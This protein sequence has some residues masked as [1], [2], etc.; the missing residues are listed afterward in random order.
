MNAIK[1]TIVMNVNAQKRIIQQTQV[2]HLRI[3]LF[4]EPGMELIPGS[5]ARWDDQQELAVR[6]E[7]NGRASYED[8]PQGKK[9]PLNA[10]DVLLFSAD[11]IHR[12]LYGLDRLAFDILVF[13]EAG[14][15]IDYIDDDCLPPAV[16]M[17]TIKNPRIF[18][19]A[20]AL[21]AQ[22]KRV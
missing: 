10:G 8:L 21:K 17:N 11:M 20:R 5:H 4:N 14:D 12:G 16:M 9:I 6:L 7:L 22:K 19:N 2:L 15:Y 1:K 18:I 3:P 13:D